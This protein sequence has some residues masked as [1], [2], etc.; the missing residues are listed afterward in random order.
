MSR[1]QRILLAVIILCI[2]LGVGLLLSPKLSHAPFE[3]ASSSSDSVVISPE[4]LVFQ[5]AFETELAVVY[6]SSTKGFE[7]EKL[8]QVFPGLKAE[9]FNGVEAVIGRY[10]YSNGTT[11]YTNNQITDA[12]A[13]DISPK[14]YEVLRSNLYQ[15]LNLDSTVEVGIVLE[16]VMKDS[17]VDAPT[18]NACQLDA[19]ICPDGSAVGREGTECEFA[20]CPDSVASS[21]IVCTDEQREVNACIELYAPVCASVEVQCVTTPCNPIPETFSNG[22]FACA[23]KQVKSYVEGECPTPVL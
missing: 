8:L 16:Q 6:G 22:C 3:E 20:A 14:G 18:A 13:D 9:D 4:A 12:T 11:T 21:Q 5:T 23:N 1:N 17:R 19:K 7:P 10:E 15:R 2:G